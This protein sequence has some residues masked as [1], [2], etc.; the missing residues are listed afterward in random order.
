T[1]AERGDGQRRFIRLTGTDGRDNDL[2][3]LAAIGR[4][5]R[6][7]ADLARAQWAENVSGVPRLVQLCSQLA[8]R[9]LYKGGDREE[10]CGSGEEERQR[11]V[12][13]REGL[14]P[15]GLL[16]EPAE[17]STCQMSRKGSSFRAS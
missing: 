10:V 9:L 8:A 7:L 3:E 13:E 15:A 6:A 12:Q 1:R 16:L 11:E 2:L 17:A 4:F 5:V 14:R